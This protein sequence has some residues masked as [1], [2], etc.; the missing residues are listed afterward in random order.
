MQRLLFLCG[1]TA[2][3]LLSRGRAEGQDDQY[4][5]IYGLI[6]EGDALSASGD[7]TQALARYLDAQSALQR[8]QTTFPDWNP[9]LV[10]YRI[11]YLATKISEATSRPEATKSVE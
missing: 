6:Q 11:G 3:V 4:L 10:K 8:F 1:L 5:H 2:L 7:S 9:G